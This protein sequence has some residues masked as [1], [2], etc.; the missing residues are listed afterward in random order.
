MSHTDPFCPAVWFS[1]EIVAEASYRAPQA[2]RLFADYCH[3]SAA[4]GQ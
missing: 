2:L 1:N 3:F 4:A